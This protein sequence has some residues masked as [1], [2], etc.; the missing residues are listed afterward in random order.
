MQVIPAIDLMQ[1]PSNQTLVMHAKFGLRS[2]YQPISSCL[3]LSALPI[4][5][6]TGLL[7]L[8]PFETIYIADLDA[9][10]GTGNQQ[11]AIDEISE[12]FPQ[13]IIWLDCGIDRRAHV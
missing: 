13:L 1:G 3:S 7:E 8:Y 12:Q 5:I 4:D 6:V 9:I 2:H 11:A 10:C